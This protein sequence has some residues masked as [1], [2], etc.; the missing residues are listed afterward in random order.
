MRLRE[1]LER[2]AQEAPQSLDIGRPWAE[3]Q[4]RMFE[5]LIRYYKIPADLRSK[6]WLFSITDSRSR[7]RT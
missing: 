1:I 4:R 2:R 3:S 6:S 7:K 5:L